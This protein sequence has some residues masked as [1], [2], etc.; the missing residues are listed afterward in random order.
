MR[1]WQRGKQK[2]EWKRG[3][4]LVLPPS[5]TIWGNDDLVSFFNQPDIFDR[6]MLIFWIVDCPMHPQLFE[7]PPETR[8]VEGL[9]CRYSDGIEGLKAN[10][11]EALSA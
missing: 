2:G 9:V 11:V 10:I 4:K 5:K 3:R 6:S 8:F 1:Y 7:V